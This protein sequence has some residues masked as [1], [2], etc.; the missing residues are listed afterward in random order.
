V[1]VSDKR[2]GKSEEEFSVCTKV[3]TTKDEG[4]ENRNI[5]SLKKKKI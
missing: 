2:L 3:T 4:Y 1:R 5:F